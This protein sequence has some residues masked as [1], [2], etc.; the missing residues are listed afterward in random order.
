MDNHFTR[1]ERRD[2]NRHKYRDYGQ[3]SSRER[4]K[5]NDRESYRG[6]DRDNSRSRNLANR[7]P[8]RNQDNVDRNVNSR[9][10]FKH[11]SSSVNQRGNDKRSGYKR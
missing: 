9:T 7:S 6:G 4:Y 3:R 1:D 2:Q 8:E 10:D 11:R 5:S